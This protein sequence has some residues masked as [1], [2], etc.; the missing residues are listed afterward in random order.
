MTK[1]ID[2]T[3][4]RFG[5]L[6][7]LSPSKEK[8]DSFI[9]WECRCDCGNLTVVRG[10]SLRNGDTKSC[11][12]Y[13]KEA[14]ST[15]HRT[16]GMCK[17]RIYNIWISMKSRCYKETDCSYELYGGRG[18]QVCKEWL[19]SFE[20]FRDWAFA[21][22]YASNLT[23]DRINNDGNYEPSNCRWATPKEQANNRRKRRWRRRP[24]SE[25]VRKG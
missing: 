16:H 4:Q 23:I 24:I 20:S 7:A 3:G 8:R 19:S 5:R 1:M 21:H 18:I 11:G 12:C 14:R 2:V 17:T 10:S 9:M 13:E 25:N 22:G 15:T 6:V